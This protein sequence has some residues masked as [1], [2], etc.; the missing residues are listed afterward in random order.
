MVSASDNEYG[1]HNDHTKNTTTP[2]PKTSTANSP[3]ATSGAGYNITVTC[4]TPPGKGPMHD[5]TDAPTGGKG[6]G[7]YTWNQATTAIFGGCADGSYVPPKSGTWANPLSAETAH[8]AIL[9]IK[10]MLHN[11]ADDV[12]TAKRQIL[13]NHWSG[14][15]SKAFAKVIDAFTQYVKDLADTMT[16]PPSGTSLLRIAH[17]NEAL[18]EACVFIWESSARGDGDHDRSTPVTISG[19]LSFNGTMLEAGQKM[20]IDY[21]I[22]LKKLFE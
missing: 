14:P 16:Y 13:D 12:D 11:Y 22:E 2:N 19:D 21:D 15:A 3:S 5:A 4:G 18:A 9:S 20:V 7:G 8:W 6:F 1:Q 10:Q 17:M